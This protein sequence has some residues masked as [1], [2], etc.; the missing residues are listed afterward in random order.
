[1]LRQR[2]WIQQHG[3]SAT[4]EE[5]DTVRTSIDAARGRIDTQLDQIER[6]RAPFT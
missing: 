6:A 1:M 2:L 5:L 4:L 3:A